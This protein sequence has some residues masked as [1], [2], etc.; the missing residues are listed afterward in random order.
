MSSAHRHRVVALVLPGVITFDLACAVQVFRW[1]PGLPLRPGHYDFRTAAATRS[2]VTGDDLRLS[3]DDGLEA[4]AEADTVVVPGSVLAGERP[5]PRVLAA[6]VAAHERGARMVSICV[7]AFAFGY[8]GLLDG[9]QVTTH[10]SFAPMLADLFPQTTVVPDVLYVDEGDLLSSAGLAAGLDLCL[11]VVRKDH[12]ADEAAQL[13][14]WNVVAPHREGGQAQFATA[15]VAASPDLGLAGTRAWAL[16]RL[17]DELD[18]ADLAAHACCSERTLT[19]RFR[20]ETGQS[21]K[22][23][24]LAA[25][26][27]R[28]R[29][30]LETTDLPIEQVASRS[31]LGSGAVLRE[32]MASVLG[33]SPT[34]YRR[35]FRGRRPAASA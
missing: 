4:L 31:G 33:T 30:L 14:R 27:E 7:G 17:E 25:R 32:R 1:A 22:Q 9:R 34:A 21:P 19:R 15:P 20:A 18:L 24:L 35:T 5:S 23:W 8:A 11:H 16:E 6:L 3:V 13:A 26:L 28:A 2:V 29:A 12:G 10:W